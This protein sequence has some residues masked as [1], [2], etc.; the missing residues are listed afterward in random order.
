MPI[1]ITIST[2]GHRSLGNHLE[3]R[4]CV[5]V[6]GLR[7]SNASQYPDF[8]FAGHFTNQIVAYSR[9]TML[10]I[11]C[12]DKRISCLIMI[13]AIITAEGVLSPYKALIMERRLHLSH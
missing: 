2:A 10:R 3:K 4:L 11:I 13:R 7:P 5:T 1:T 9:R 12:R 8:D 6:C